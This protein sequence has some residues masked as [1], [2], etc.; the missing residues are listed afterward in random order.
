MFLNYY[1]ILGIKPGADLASIKLAFNKL[2]RLYHPDKNPGDPVAEEIMKNLNQA[3]RTLSDYRLRKDHDELILK[4]RAGF[5]PTPGYADKPGE[6]FANSKVDD[7][8]K[9]IMEYTSAIKA[10]PNDAA[11]YFNRAAA[12]KALSGSDFAKA[13]EIN[14]TKK[15]WQSQGGINRSGRW[16]AYTVGFNIIR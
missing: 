6:Q 5:A 10:N 7:L 14:K 9:A 12:Y 2:A 11:A 16:G 1:E 4:N 13:R 8:H 15:K 3:L